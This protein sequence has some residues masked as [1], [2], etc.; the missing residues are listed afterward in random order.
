MGS[1]GAQSRIAAAPHKRAFFCGFEIFW[2]AKPSLMSIRQKW[3][4]P[5]KN[6]G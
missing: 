6:K 4:F 3:D 5:R 2:S 1:V